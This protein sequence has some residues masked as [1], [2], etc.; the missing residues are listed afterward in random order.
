MKAEKPFPSS[1]LNQGSNGDASHE[2]RHPSLHRHR[3]W[4]QKGNGLHDPFLCDLYVL[5]GW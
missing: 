4:V 5:K 2:Y 3:G 1:T